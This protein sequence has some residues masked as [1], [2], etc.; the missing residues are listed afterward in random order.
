MTMERKRVAELIAHLAEYG[1]QYCIGNITYCEVCKEI[2]TLHEE[3]T[4]NEMGKEV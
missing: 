2:V 4:D 3:H 1:I